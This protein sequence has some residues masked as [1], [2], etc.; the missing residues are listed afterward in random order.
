MAKIKRQFAEYFKAIQGDIFKFCQA[1]KF[2]PTWQQRELLEAVQRGDSRIAVRS[3]QGPGK[4]CSTSLVAMWRCLQRPGALTVVTAPS[5]RQCVD[6]FMKEVRNHY[7]R[8][9]GAL[10]RFFTV[11]NTRV[12]LAGMKDWGIQLATATRPENFQGFHDPNMT[13]I[14]EEASGIDRE[15]ITT[16][17]GTLT[18]PNAMFIAI[19]NP[20]TRS[21]EFFNCFHSQKHSWSTLAWNAEQT[22]E[23]EWFSHQRNREIEDEFGRE[24]DVYRVRVL[25]EFPHADPNCVL[26]SEELEL[27]MDKG[28]ILPM[29]RLTRE[30]FNL[31]ARQF[32]IDFARY[33]GDENTIFRRSGNAIVQWDFFPHTDP[34]DVVDLAFKWQQQ[35]GWKDREVWYV[36]DAGGMGQGVMGNF[37]RANRNLMEFHS[38][39]RAVQT[40][41]YDNRITEAWFSLAKMVREQRCYVPRDNQMLMQLTN[42]RYFTTKKG[43]IV[44]ESKDDYM[45]R[46]Y[47]SPDRADGLV[48][49][50]YDQPVS[51]GAVSGRHFSTH[52]VGMEVR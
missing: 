37:R 19:G 32:G 20:N 1:L 25:G 17:K 35:A 2:E 11:T 45:K 50:F 51:A 16:I 31:P 13:I 10:K 38:N 33:G 40:R 15:I 30:P 3:G 4:T 18:N 48:M 7:N 6:V 22:P 21:C 26:S 12:I 34:N 29:A 42:R 36:A 47:D 8:M 41:Q 14:A 52:K 39:G 24:S 23:S 27:V 46:G 43:K 49:A 9:D 5:M 44:L 28:L